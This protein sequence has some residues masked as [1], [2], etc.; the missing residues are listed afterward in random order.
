MRGR[1]RHINYKEERKCPLFADTMIA[2]IKNPRESA[3]ELLEILNE[4]SK[5]LGFKANIQKLIVFL[6]ISNE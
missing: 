4:F 1:K 3:K 5:V 6:Y 2:Y